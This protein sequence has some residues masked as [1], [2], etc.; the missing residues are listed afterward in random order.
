[1][2]IEKNNDAG[3][4]T[5]FGDIITR[6]TGSWCSDDACGIFDI[7]VGSNDIDILYARFLF[8]KDFM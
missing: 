6:K 3:D 7:S 1:M 2:G 4:I 8:G 5:R